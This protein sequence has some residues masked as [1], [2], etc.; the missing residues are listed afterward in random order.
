MICSFWSSSFKSGVFR[1]YEVV[2]VSPAAFFLEGSWAGLILAVLIERGVGHRKRVM[3]QERCYENKEIKL[4]VHIRAV[5]AL[6]LF[7]ASLIVVGKLLLSCPLG[8]FG[9]LSFAPT[10]SFVAITTDCSE[11]WDKFS[12]FHEN[13]IAVKAVI[14]SQNAVRNNWFELWLLLQYEQPLYLYMELLEG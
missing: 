6:S 8:C 10:I 13:S 5:A 14:L 4:R 2:F 12:A 11:V 9:F 1:L 3:F 7:F